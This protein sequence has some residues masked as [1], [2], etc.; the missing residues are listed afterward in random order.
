MYNTFTPEPPRTVHTLG[1]APQRDPGAWKKAIG[2]KPVAARL[3][4]LPDGESRKSAVVTSI[5]FQS[6]AAI[7]VV[8]LPLFFPEQ[9]KISA[10]YQVV[11]VAPLKTE[12][13]LPR[14]TPPAVPKPVRTALA[15]PIPPPMERPV[16][17]PRLTRNTVFAPAM[18]KPKP[19]P[20]EARRTEVA[21]Q[22]NQTF[23]DVKLVENP[24]EPV[25]PREPVKTGMIATGS[26][27][28]ATLPK[29]VDVAKVQTGGFGDERGLPGESKP[30]RAATIERL[31]SPVLPSGP[32]YGNGTGGASGVRGTVAS[33]GFGNGVAIQQQSAS[34]ARTEVRGGG[35]AK[36]EVGVEA[37][38]AR[39][40]EA[41][42]AVQPVVILEKPNPVYTDDARRMGL[43]GEVLIEVVFPAG[44]T[45]R[46]VRVIKGLGHGLDEAAIRA[47]QQ[48]RFKPALQQGKPVDFPATVHIVFQLAF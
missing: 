41:A 24:V 21:P 45:V 34:A 17:E 37:P 5:I 19:A 48:I 16:P 29:T 1:P 30:N 7:I 25:R 38:R 9:L 8:S 32:G 39:E 20:V 26:A 14:P 11:P 18:A 33:S 10:I 23:T 22:I 44:G 46:V 35:F 13:V 47:A 31:G 3:A 42:A 27:A 4:L 15:R 6:I 12:F 36:A 2:S 43:E 28:P 40:V